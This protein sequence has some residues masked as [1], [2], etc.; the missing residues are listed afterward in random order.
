MIHLNEQI[1]IATAP[2][3][4]EPLLAAELAALGAACLLYTSR[5]V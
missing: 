3:G 2:E 4:I 5:C 1:F